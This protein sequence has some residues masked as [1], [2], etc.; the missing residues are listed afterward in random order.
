MCITQIV[1][2]INAWLYAVSPILYEVKVQQFFQPNIKQ[3]QYKNNSA[4]MQWKAYASILDIT[5]NNFI[6]RNTWNRLY[7]FD[8][9]LIKVSEE[10]KWYNFLFH[11]NKRNS[12]HNH[13]IKNLY[14][15]S[16]DYSKGF[17]RKKLMKWSFD[18]GN[19]YDQRLIRGLFYM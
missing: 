6:E 18:L 15:N 3:Q 13:I 8:I 7:S 5:R 19:I 10:E 11:Q 12:G 17:T 2:V 4:V 14:H 16:R 9:D 1:E